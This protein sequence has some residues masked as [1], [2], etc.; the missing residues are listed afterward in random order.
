M[1]TIPYIFLIEDNEQDEIL[2]IKALKKNKVLNEIKVARDGAEALDILFKEDAPQYAVDLPQLILLDLKL[3]KIDG[4]EVLKQI[5][6]NPKT[7]LIPVVILT[8]SKED[9][10]L[11]SGYELGAN[12]YVRKPVDFHEFAEAVKNLGTYWLLLNERAPV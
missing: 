5:R 2:T 4:L 1:K 11:V 12:S 9:S 8:T 10:D 7:K 3:P 6:C